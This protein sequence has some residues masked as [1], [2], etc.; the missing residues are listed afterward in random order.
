VHRPTG[1]ALPRGRSPPGAMSCPEQPSDSCSRRSL[2]QCNSQSDMW[3]EQAVVVHLGVLPRRPLEPGQ[4]GTRRQ[5]QRIDG[6][7]DR[8][9]HPGN[10]M[11]IQATMRTPRRRRARAR[12]SR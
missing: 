11:V 1:T 12:N 3:H 7:D 2:L 4:I 10:D 6:R 5:A 9:G 8:T